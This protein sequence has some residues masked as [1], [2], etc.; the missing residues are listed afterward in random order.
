[1]TDDEIAVPVWTLATE[2]VHVPRVIGD[3]VMTPERL[4]ELRSALAAFA[5]TPIATLAVH[6][7]PKELDRSRGIHLE[8]T[9]P[10]A[11]HL[12]QLITQTTASAPTAAKVGS[13]EALYRM[14]VPAK[15]AAQFGKGLVRSMTSK[16]GGVHSALVGPSGIAAQASF[17]PVTGA[18][19]KAAG[20]AGVAAAG[21]TA[22]VTVAAPLILMAVAVALSARADNQRQ[23]AMANITELLEKLHEHNLEEERTRLDGC[24]AAVDKATAV[25]LDDGRLGMALGIGEAVSTVATALAAARRRLTRWQRALA[26]LPDGPVEVAPLIKA[27][28][29]IDKPGGEFRAH[30]ELAAMAIALEKRILVIQAVEHA[31]NEGSNHPFQS[32]IRALRSS[33]RELDELESGITTVVRRLSA[34]ELTRTHGLR[35]FVFSPGEIDDL[36][37][38]IYQLRELAN[39]IEPDTP[40]PDVA[41]EMARARDGSLVVFPALTA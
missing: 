29:G 35:D 9:S 36:L 10:L 39:S 3:D 22:A 13:G 4:A 37:R 33:Q 24:R 28:P 6:P 7:L 20:A 38:T 41:I 25:L 18:A 27:F 32:F 16:A 17:V 19:T 8:S 30:L 12:S 26:K 40:Q 14:V 1:M 34:L 5:N 15:V 2:D 23:Q 21:A 11:Q 31:Q